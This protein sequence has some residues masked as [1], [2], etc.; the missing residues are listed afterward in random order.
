MIHDCYWKLP[1]HCYWQKVDPGGCS[2]ANAPPSTAAAIPSW[3]G[4]RGAPEQLPLWCWQATALY[5]VLWRQ[6]QR[7]EGFVFLYLLL[8]KCDL[9][10]PGAGGGSSNLPPAPAIISSWCRQLG[11]GR[12]E[13]GEVVKS[14]SSPCLSPA[15]DCSS[16]CMGI[17]AWLG[18]A[19]VK[20]TMRKLDTCMKN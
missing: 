5:R 6:Q 20:V 17:L 19:V 8:P 16:S 4:S 18:T 9:Q 3:P 12:G 14:V 10:W 15:V 11:A 13:E 7:Q 2:R 1:V